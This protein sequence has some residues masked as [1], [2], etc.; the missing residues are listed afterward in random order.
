M[1]TTYTTYKYKLLTVYYPVSIEDFTVNL[2]I[3]QFINNCTNF[4]PVPYFVYNSSY[5]CQR[6]QQMKEIQKVRAICM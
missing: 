3:T 6:L 2:L 5:I 1:E 4:R